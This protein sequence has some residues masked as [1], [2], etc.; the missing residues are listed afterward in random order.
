MAS[1]PVNRNIETQRPRPER[2]SQLPDDELAAIWELA[3]LDADGRLLLD[4]FAIA[5]H[6]VTRRRAGEYGAS[7]V[8]RG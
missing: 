4:E 2:W 8:R 1:V 7:T 5:M 6:L 3:D